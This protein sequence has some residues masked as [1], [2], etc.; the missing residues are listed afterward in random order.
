MNRRLGLSALCLVLSACQGSNPYTATSNP[1]PPAPPGAANTLD[2]SA[3]PAPVRD[4]GRYRSWAW[5]NDRLPAGSSWAE[6]AQVA[7]AV[8]NALEQRGLRP[9]QGN[10]PADLRV[11]ADM[12]LEKRLRQVR[13]DYG[14]GGVYGGGYG[15]GPYGNRYGMYGSMPMVRTYED[16]VVVVRINL[17]DANTGQPIWS[18]S[19][20]TRS[21]GSLSERADALRKAV[22]KA[23]T[24]Y[25]PS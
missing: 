18:A 1:L 23:L 22:E 14:Y 11:S 3:Y 17:F 2:L 13:D 5:L 6:P 9:T 25:P 16:E 20:E 8:S 24:A 7:E 15:G 4:Y 10:R 12:R 21:Q 19:A